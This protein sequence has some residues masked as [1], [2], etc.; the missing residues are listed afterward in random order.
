MCLLSVRNT[1]KL[2]RITHETVGNPQQHLDAR[3]YLQISTFFRGFES[4]K[5]RTGVYQD[6]L[7]VSGVGIASGKIKTGRAI[8]DTTF[9]T[10]PRVGKAGVDVEGD[11]R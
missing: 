4:L 5:E 10:F 9:G 8:R 6:G 11:S 1:T 2:F 7:L 3:D